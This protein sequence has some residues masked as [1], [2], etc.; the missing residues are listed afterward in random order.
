[1]QMFW[2][3]ADSWEEELQG[4]WCL[5]LKALLWLPPLSSASALHHWDYGKE[6]PG[7]KC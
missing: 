4:R 5:R 7:N 6:N 2:A 1:M 3:A